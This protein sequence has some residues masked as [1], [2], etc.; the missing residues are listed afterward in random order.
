MAATPAA[1]GPTIAS[2][3]S[4]I[5]ANGI[6][7]IV[8]SEHRSKRRLAEETVNHTEHPLASF[9]VRGVDL[10]LVFGPVSSFDH[11]ANE[12][13]PVL[14][15]WTPVHERRLR[16]QTVAFVE[17]LPN[18]LRAGSH[19]VV[20][21]TSIDVAGCEMQL[22]VFDCSDGEIVDIRASPHIIHVDVN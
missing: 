17:S 16:R 21:R 11:P 1:T 14:C 10:R 8:T 12:F 13:R 18:A 19:V 3:W 4:T 20:E 22:G 5:N 2:T 7:C 6:P 15:V 9:G